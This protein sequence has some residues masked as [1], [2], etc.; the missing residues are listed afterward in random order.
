MGPIKIVGGIFAAIALFA[1]MS[2]WFA[3]GMIHEAWVEASRKPTRVQQPKPF[4]SQLGP[5]AILAAVCV[6]LHVVAWLLKLALTRR[7]QLLG[8]R[9]QFWSVLSAAA[10][11]VGFLGG[12][13]LYF[14][15]M[16]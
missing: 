15:S 7:E 1:G 9:S 13:L 12:A 6:G 5:I 14:T 8:M 16:D 2:V 4:S 11:T 10:Y 3:L